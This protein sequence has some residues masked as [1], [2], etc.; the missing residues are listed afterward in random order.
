M[1]DTV[2]ELMLKVGMNVVTQSITREYFY[3][4]LMMLSAGEDAVLA[5]HLLIAQIEHAYLQLITSAESDSEDDPGLYYQA[6]LDIRDGRPHLIMVMDSLQEDDLKPVQ[7]EGLNALSNTQ[8]A[9]MPVAMTPLLRDNL[10]QAMAE[11]LYNKMASCSMTDVP[12]MQ[13]QRTAN[14]QM[15]QLRLFQIHEAT[16]EYIH[17]SATTERAIL[18]K[19]IESE[20]D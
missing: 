4:L 7:M 20:G 10:P 1:F 9:N 16:C 11:I 5:Y 8:L 19:M 2:K 3:P 6:L 12:I 15:E 17:C 14:H 13:T 18:K